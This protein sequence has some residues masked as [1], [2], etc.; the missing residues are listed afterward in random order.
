MAA[1]QTLPNELKDL[2]I[3]YCISNLLS[4]A[5][6]IVPDYSSVESNLPERRP[7]SRLSLPEGGKPAVELIVRRHIK[8]ILTALPGMQSTI[9]ATWEKRKSA[10]IKAERRI[11]ER[12]MLQYYEAVWAGTDRLNGTIHPSLVKRDTYWV[13]RTCVWYWLMVIMCEE[14]EPRDDADLST[15]DVE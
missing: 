7:S 9:F 13:P 10:E 11:E 5:F 1:I 8:A 4:S 6:R 14:L 12:E 2:I 15:A 3:D